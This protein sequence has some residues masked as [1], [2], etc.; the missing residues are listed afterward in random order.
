MTTDRSGKLMDELSDRVKPYVRAMLGASGLNE[1]D[2]ITSV[3]FAITTHIDLGQYPILVY[4]GA[5]ATGKSEAMKQLFPMCRGAKRIQGR[6]YAAHRN[7]L[8]EGVRT[9][10]VDE[11]DGVDTN[12]DLTDLY[13]K[14]YSKETGTMQV[15][16]PARVGREWELKP[17]DIF[18]ATVMAKRTA[19]ADVAL[20][21]R[22]I[23]IRTTY[24]L[25]NYKVTPIGNVSGIASSVADRA[26]RRLSEIG[27]V[28]R[29]WQTW[30]PLV[31]IA[32]ELGMTEWEREAN[33]VIVQEAEALAGGQGYEP[34]EAIL[35]AINILSR[36]GVN[37]NRVDK[38]I[39]IS[40]VVRVVKEEF[41]LALKP[42]QIKEEAEARGFQTSTLHGYPVIKVKKD[43]LDRLLPE[44]G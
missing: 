26:K 27:G 37:G 29:V 44:E 1:F 16:E 30:S 14:R 43:L 31:T 9:A 41:A 13:T 21:S 32:K 24:R 23:I 18:G 7:E 28:D 6:T 38:P 15:N 12:A 2:A 3:L 39:H 11:A 20:R 4:L 42:N 36:D 25:R 35:Q 5:R 10:L 34:S 8:K 22:C 40:E 19:I 33:D 17:H